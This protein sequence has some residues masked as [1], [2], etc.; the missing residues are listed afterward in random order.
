MDSHEV[1]AI[2]GRIYRGDSGVLELLIGIQG[3]P[4]GDGDGYGGSSLGGETGRDK[5]AF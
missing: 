2:S 5:E 1:Q 3:H 4:T